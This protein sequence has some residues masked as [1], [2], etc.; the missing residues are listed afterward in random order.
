MISF[1]ITLTWLGR[2]AATSDAEYI[3]IEGEAAGLR[4]DLLEKSYKEV[5]AA[6][7]IDVK[8]FDASV[9]TYMQEGNEELFMIHASLQQHLM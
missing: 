2:R 1:D 9:E 4:E 8:E 5:L 6:L 7:N 3:Q